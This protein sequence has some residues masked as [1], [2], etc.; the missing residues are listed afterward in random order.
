MQDEYNGNAI[1]NTNPLPNEENTAK[2]V[3]FNT[4]EIQMKPELQPGTFAI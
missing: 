4:G 1:N 2:A 3:T